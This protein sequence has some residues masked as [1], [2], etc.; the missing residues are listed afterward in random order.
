[1][2]T[3][4]TE[5]PFGDQVGIVLVRQLGRQ[6]VLLERLRVGHRQQLHAGLEL[7][8]ARTTP[9]GLPAISTVAAISPDFTF[10]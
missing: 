7:E 6:V 9:V 10:W 5:L 8:L 1:M 3:V 2:A 4:S